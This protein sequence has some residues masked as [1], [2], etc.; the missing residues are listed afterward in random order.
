MSEI[1]QVGVEEFIRTIASRFLVPAPTIERVCR[2]EVWKKDGTLIEDP[3]PAYFNMGPD[4]YE[5]SV[6]EIK[7][8]FDEQA[9]RKN[10]VPDEKAIEAF[11]EKDISAQPT[12]PVPAKVEEPKKVKK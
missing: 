8:Y 7:R 4:R 1:T 5:I 9:L 6:D 12:N 3:H 11:M 2:G 10:A